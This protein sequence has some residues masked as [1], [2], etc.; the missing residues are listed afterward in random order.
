MPVPAQPANLVLMQGMGTEVILSFGHAPPPVA[1]ATMEEDQQAEYLK[2][3]HV[4][5]Q[6]I[7][8]FTMPVHV[9]RLL[10]NILQ[11]NLG[12]RDADTEQKVTP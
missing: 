4:K 9:A 6:Q 8:R 7:V 2:G 1:M 10:M 3:R 12:P 5:V 11:A